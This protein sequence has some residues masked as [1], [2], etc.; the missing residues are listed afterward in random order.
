MIILGKRLREVVRGIPK[1]M[2]VIHNKPFLH[3]LIKLWINKGIFCIWFQGA[4][5]KYV[6]EIISLG[7]GEVNNFCTEESTVR[8]I[9]KY[10]IDKVKI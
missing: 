1:P 3:Y 7:T 10:V 8:S 6:E 4:S 2:A 5:I 9:S